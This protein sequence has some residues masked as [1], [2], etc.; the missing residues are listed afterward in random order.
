MLMT[1]RAEACSEVAP[2]GHTSLHTEK[3]CVEKHTF[4]REERHK[5]KSDQVAENLL[6]RYSVLVSFPVGS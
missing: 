2:L 5:G 1:E 6:S 3:I 4:Q